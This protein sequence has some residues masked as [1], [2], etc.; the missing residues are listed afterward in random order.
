M[1]SKKEEVA[2]AMRNKLDIDMGTTSLYQK[3][4]WSDFDYVAFP[5][6]G[7]CLILSNLWVMTTT[8]LGNTLANI[9]FN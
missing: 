3:P 7:V 4:Y 6:V 1:F 2:N 5:L 8:Q 9:L